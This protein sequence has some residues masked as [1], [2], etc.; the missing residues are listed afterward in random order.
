ML[1][2][3]M[4]FDGEDSNK[5]GYSLG[6]VDRYFWIPV[7]YHAQVPNHRLSMRMNLVSGKF[8]LYRYYY[9]DQIE[10]ILIEGSLEEVVSQCNLE[11]KRF[12]D[13]FTDLDE[14]G[15]NND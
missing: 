15:E 3:P 6:E 14:V 11:V 2:S 1:I 8:E 13:D 9:D 5:P 10:E 12:H 7:K 4:M